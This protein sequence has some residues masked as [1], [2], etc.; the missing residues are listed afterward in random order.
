M[1]EGIKEGSDFMLSSIYVE[2]IV[3][4]KLL[5]AL[6]VEINHIFSFGQAKIVWIGLSRM[7]LNIICNRLKISLRGLG[8]FLV[9]TVGLV[10]AIT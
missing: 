10:G 5:E 9:C 8:T 7:F 3:K 4:K 6:Q 1:V 2:F